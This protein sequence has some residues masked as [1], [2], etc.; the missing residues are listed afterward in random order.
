MAQPSNFKGKAVLVTGAAAGLGAA[1]ALSFAR[2]G[3]DLCL[4]DISADGLA[5]TADKARGL[6][7]KAIECPLDL[8]IA[9]NCPAAVR[10]AVNAFG[11]LD[12][13]C[14]VAA[15]MIPCHTADM[16]VQDFQRTIA[17]NF[18]APF[19]LM[20]SAIPHLLQSRGA[21]VNV[22][23]AVGIVAQAYTA[24]YCA[25]KAALIHLT[26]SMAMEYMNTPLRINSVAPGAMMTALI[27]NM[28][29]LQ[30]YDPTLM[31]RCAPLRGFVEVDD[32]AKMIVFLASDAAQ[33]YHGSCV[34]IDNGMAAG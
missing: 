29:S 17:V 21:V 8:S 27:N 1:T 12:A 33:G 10:G 14:N 31:S 28:A 23:S 30:E 9:E 34:T 2:E 25:T 15:V 16:S 6:G 19:L 24:A 11:R 5:E 32:V 26:K 18:A 4:V 7:V 3:A 20:Q 13:L 22:A